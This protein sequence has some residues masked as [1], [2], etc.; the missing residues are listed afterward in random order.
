MDDDEIIRKIWKD[1]DERKSAE[2]IMERQR[3]G[4]EKKGVRKGY[5]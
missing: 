4:S 5:V 2:K 3:K 1:L